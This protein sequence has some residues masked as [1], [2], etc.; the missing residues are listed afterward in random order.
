PLRVE[1]RAGVRGSGRLPLGTRVVA[2]DRGR[3]HDVAPFHALVVLRARERAA[4]GCRPDLEPGAEPERVGGADGVRVEAVLAEGAAAAV[5][6]VD[7]ERALGL[8]GRHEDR[9][10]YRPTAEGELDHVLGAH[11]EAARGR[12]GDL[13]GI[14]PGEAAHGTR[15][16]LE[17]GVRCEATVVHHRIG[18]EDDLEAL[19]AAWSRRRRSS[20]KDVARR[21]RR[22]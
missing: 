20:G 2:L 12:R 21:E 18:T 19:L 7:R 13:H 22:P 6:E 11:A 10:L 4:L 9:R 17:P 16:L 1:A 15:Q 5:P 14:V 8:P 3:A